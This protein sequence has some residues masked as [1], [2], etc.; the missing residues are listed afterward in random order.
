MGCDY[1][2]LPLIP[3]SGTTLLKCAWLY[4][5]S[6][7]CHNIIY[8]HN[9]AK[10]K[11]PVGICMLYS[12]KWTYIHRHF[13][14]K[15]YGYVIMGAIASQLTSL[16]IVYSTVYSDADQRKHQSSASPAFVWG[17]HRGP[18]NSPHKW[19]A[20]RKM[21]PFDDVINFFLI[22]DNKCFESW[23]TRGS[24]INL[25]PWGLNKVA[26]IMQK[27]ISNAFYRIKTF[28]IGIKFHWNMFARI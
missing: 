7:K 18:V 22:Q 25:K 13:N 21:F 1:L 4:H 10:H 12:V 27:A 26:D 15:H 17:I 11:I 3:A 28:N 16:T 9:N 8:N 14:T 2:S 24:S 5:E 19:P 20:T 6:P 23:R